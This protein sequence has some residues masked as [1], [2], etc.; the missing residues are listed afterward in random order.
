MPVTGKGAAK[1][2]SKEPQETAQDT[3]TA[4]TDKSR[5]KSIKLRAKRFMSW[6]CRGVKIKGEPEKTADGRVLTSA[7]GKKTMGKI[8]TIYQDM[9]PDPKAFDE[10]VKSLIDNEYFEIV[11]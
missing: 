4:Q 1:T 5:G 2:S 8:I 10:V 6:D 11:N 9:W 3:K 7:D